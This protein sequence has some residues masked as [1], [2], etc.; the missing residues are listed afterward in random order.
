MESGGKRAC[1][2]SIDKDGLSYLELKLKLS[3]L[4]VS[5]G[6]GGA[7]WRPWSFLL[8]CRLLMASGGWGSPYLPMCTTGE[9][10]QAPKGS[11]KLRVPQISLV[12]QSGSQQ[13]T[14]QK[15]LNVRKRL[16]GSRGG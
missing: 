1:F 16:V 8:S 15:D 9:P 10:N 4:T 3:A 13:N 2:Q 14:K 12:K 6:Q 5:H 11:S 7:H